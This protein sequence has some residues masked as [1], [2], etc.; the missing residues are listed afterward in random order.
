M[1]TFNSEKTIQKYIEDINM[2]GFNVKNLFSP[3]KL[4]SQGNSVN[5]Q[6][7]LEPGTYPARLCWLILAGVQDQGEYAGKAKEPRLEMLLGYEFL[8]EFCVDEDGNEDET[9]PRFLSE[10]FPF[11]SLDADRARSTV[12]YMALDPSLALDGD[13]EPLVGQVLNLTISKK[14][15]KKSGRDYNSVSSVSRMREKDAAKYEGS[16]LLDTRI[17]NIYE[18]DVDTFLALPKWIQ[19]KIKGALDYS[20]SPL[21]GL[22]KEGSKAAEEAPKS[23]KVKSKKE[24]SA[25]EDDDSDW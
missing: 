1:W 24:E 20:D 2:A 16:G 9:K 4:P 8:D 25:E 21:E 10:N 6:E 12:R 5:R 15:S 22:L 14:T 3:K 23:P 18:P 19:G 11:Y 13:W 7:A 17:F